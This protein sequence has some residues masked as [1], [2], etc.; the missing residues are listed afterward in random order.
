[1]PASEGISLARVMETPPMI[2]RAARKCSAAFT[3]R[4]PLPAGALP[5]RMERLTVSAF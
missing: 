5:F 3:M 1:M 4:L 2:W